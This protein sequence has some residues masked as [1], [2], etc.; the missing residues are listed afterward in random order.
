MTRQP[1]RLP[2]SVESLRLEKTKYLPIDTAVSIAPDE[3]LRV[4]IDL[5]GRPVAAKR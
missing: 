3:T 4:E 5:I 1:E 2:V